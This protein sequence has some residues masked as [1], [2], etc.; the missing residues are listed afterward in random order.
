MI[1]EENKQ[2]EQTTKYMKMYVKPKQ[3]TTRII[4]MIKLGNTDT[5]NK[6]QEYRITSTYEGKPYQKY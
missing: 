5:N 6:Q 4:L 2:N 3:Y 1:H